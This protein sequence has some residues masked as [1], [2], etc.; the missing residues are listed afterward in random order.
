MTVI[1]DDDLRDIFAPLSPGVKLTVI[2]DC[3]HRWALATAS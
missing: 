2:A 3:C 1:C